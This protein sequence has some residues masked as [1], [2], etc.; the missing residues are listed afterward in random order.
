M[1]QPPGCEAQPRLTSVR[2]LQDQ[3]L[4]PDCCRPSRT[5]TPVALRAAKSLGGFSEFLGVSRVCQAVT[6]TM[7]TPKAGILSQTEAGCKRLTSLTLPLRILLGRAGQL[8]SVSR[9]V[10]LKSSDLGKLRHSFH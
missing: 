8:H 7:I 2:R 1:K 4:E 5:W 10:G 3:K 6:G 9:I